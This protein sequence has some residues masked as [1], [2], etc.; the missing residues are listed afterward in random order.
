MRLDI[1]LMHRLG[2]IA[3]LDDDVGQAEAGFRVAF[4][5]GHPFGD[6]RGLFRLGLD[7][8]GEE[9]VMQQLCIR[10]HRRLDIDDVRQHLVLDL[11]QLDRFGCDGRREGG[12]RGH[13]VAFVKRFVPGHDI[14]RQVAKVHRPFADKGLFRGDLRKV[15]CGHHLLDPGQRQGLVGVDPENAGMCMRAAFDL[16]V[17]H[18]GHCPVGPEIGAA[19]DLLDPVGA[20]GPGADNL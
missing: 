15:G 1:G 2:R 9:I 10:R 7:A 5:K 16:T 13:R 14:A 4:C 12:H 3:P 18:A 8:L 19:G 20:N 6:V 11:N 17:K